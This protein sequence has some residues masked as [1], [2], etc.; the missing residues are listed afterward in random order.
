[1]TIIYWFVHY[2]SPTHTR[3]S[4]FMGWFNCTRWGAECERTKT[5]LSSRKSVSN[6]LDERPCSYEGQRGEQGRGG[7]VGKVW[8]WRERPDGL[9]RKIPVPIQSARA[10]WWAGCGRAWMIN[11][12]EAAWQLT[13]GRREAGEGGDLS[14]SGSQPQFPRDP[15]SHHPVELGVNDWKQSSTQDMAK[16]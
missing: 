2:L 1:M 12:W 16:G 9:R 7:M 11:G 8:K 13:K 15:V 4:P 3:K 6:S 5:F 14:P 10:A